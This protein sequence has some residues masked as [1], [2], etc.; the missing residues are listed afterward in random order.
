MYIYVVMSVCICM[1]CF[2]CVY[3]IC[4]YISVCTCMYVYMYVCVCVCM[5]VCTYVCTCMYDYV[6]EY[7]CVYSNVSIVEPSNGSTTSLFQILFNLKT[8]S[9]LRK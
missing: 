5:C 2:V 9:R 3:H 4:M 1:T 8:L 6:C 7:I